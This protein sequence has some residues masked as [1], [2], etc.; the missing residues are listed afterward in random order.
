MSPRPGG[1]VSNSSEFAVMGSGEYKMRAPAKD[2]ALGIALQFLREHTGQSIVLIALAV[3][4]VARLDDVWFFHRFRVNILSYSD[5]EDFLLAAMRNTVTWIYFI[6]PAAVVLLSAWLL[7]A[8]KPMPGPESKWNSARLRLLGA[9]ALVIL[10]SAVLTKMHADR[11]ADDI[12]AGVGRH[13]SFTRS[14]GVTFDEKP[15]LLG[16]TGEFFF[17]YY[18]KRRVAE[19]VPVTNTALMTVDLHPTNDPGT[20]IPSAGGSGS[21]PKLSP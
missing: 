21:T 11:R 2:T 13:V 16:S 10:T 9:C 15:V 1:D 5:P 17:L 19:I 7:G 20:A 18:V 8:R 3:T 6:V 14:D 12:R 4:V